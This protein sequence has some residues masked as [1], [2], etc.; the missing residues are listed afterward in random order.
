MLGMGLLP[1]KKL[2]I[3]QS[4][5][6]IGLNVQRQFQTKGRIFV[7]VL[8]FVSFVSFFAQKVRPV[9]YK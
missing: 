7:T 2:A 3:Y 8:G 9:N 6:L 5:V 1:L 4:E